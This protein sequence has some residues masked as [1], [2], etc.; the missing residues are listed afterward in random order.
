MADRRRWSIVPVK[1]RSD[2]VLRTAAA[3]LAHRVA[4]LEDTC[5]GMR[6][7]LDL[8]LLRI[9]SLQLQLDHLVS[10]TTSAPVLPAGEHAQPKGGEIVN[11]AADFPDARQMADRLTRQLDTQDALKR[12]GS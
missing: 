9:A 2:D 1:D 5:A 8:Q 11:T 3:D 4:G 7:T 10:K 12:P 6:R